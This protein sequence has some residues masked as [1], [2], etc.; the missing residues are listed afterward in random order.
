MTI[1]SYNKKGD[2]A[3]LVMKI[4]SNKNRY[5]IMKTLFFARRNL[6]VNELSDTIGISQSLT[7]H[8][9][10]Y[11]EACGVV[12]GVRMGKTM[13]YEPTNAPVTKKIAKIIRF[14]K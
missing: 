3:L 10:A 4:L 6:C 7:S 14:L 9:L 12:K 5:A 8:S 11:L 1:L 2:V 13:C